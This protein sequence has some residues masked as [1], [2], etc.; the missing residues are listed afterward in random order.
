[1]GIDVYYQPIDVEFVQNEV[2]PFVSNQRDDPRII[3]AV[4]CGNIEASGIMQLRDA[5]S[6]LQSGAEYYSIPWGRCYPDEFIA[7]NLVRKVLEYCRSIFPSWH[8]R[9]IT[10]IELLPDKFPTLEHYQMPLELFSPITETFA[11]VAC[12]LETIADCEDMGGVIPIASVPAVR[13]AIRDTHSSAVRDLEDPYCY[14]ATN[15]LL[16]ALQYAE[17]HDLS[18]TEAIC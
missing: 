16:K 4:N 12:Q 11:D 13:K 7:D 3:S 10:S 8:V 14:D 15:S 9:A 5:H 17:E 6:C 1:M 18:F 2:L